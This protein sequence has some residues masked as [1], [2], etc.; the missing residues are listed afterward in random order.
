MR[1]VR[2]LSESYILRR[3]SKRRGL[4]R[5]LKANVQ[6]EMRIARGSA[7]HSGQ[8]QTKID[9]RN[10]DIRAGLRGRSRPEEL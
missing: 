3:R 6:A 5:V 8:I 10:V 7:F 2:M 9:S 4:R 1:Y